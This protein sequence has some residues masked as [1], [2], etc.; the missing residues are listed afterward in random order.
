MR[1]KAMDVDIGHRA[2]C[3]PQ[4]D[5]R[6]RCDPRDCHGSIREELATGV[7]QSLLIRLTHA[8]SASRQSLIRP[9]GR[10][11]TL[12]NKTNADCVATLETS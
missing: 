8:L 11:D 6:L 10:K 4:P 12:A 7:I 9:A 1:I 2:S 3:A 5:P